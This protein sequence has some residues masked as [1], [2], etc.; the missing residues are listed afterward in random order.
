MALTYTPIATTTVTGSAVASVTFSSIPS[1]YTDLVLIGTPLATTSGKGT[2]Y[3]E[4]N[5][6]TT[7]NYSET[8]LWGNGT[9]AN[10]GRQANSYGASIGGWDAG[11]LNTQQNNIT[12]IMNYSNITTYKTV[13]SR[14]NNSADAE[15]HV[16]LWRKTPEAINSIKIYIGFANSSTNQDTLAVGSVFT[17]YGITAA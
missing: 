8:I 6:D 11:V 1:T 12:H 15:V 10:S 4:F 2:L 9:S 5:G 17:L 3:V 13:L 7:S 14:W 16:S